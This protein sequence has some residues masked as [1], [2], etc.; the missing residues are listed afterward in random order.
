M[1]L[2]KLWLLLI[3]LKACGVHGCEPPDK[4]WNMCKNDLVTLDENCL[5][6][7]ICYQSKLAKDSGNWKAGNRFR[8]NSPNENI[9]YECAGN[10]G[11][12]GWHAIRFSNDSTGMVTLEASFSS[13]LLIFNASNYPKINITNELTSDGQFVGEDFW[14]AL[15]LGALMIDFDGIAF[16]IAALEIR[17]FIGKKD[18][19]LCKTKC[20]KEPI[21]I[22]WNNEWIGGDTV[23][24]LL[25]RGFPRYLPLTAQNE[26]PF[27]CQYTANQSLEDDSSMFVF[28]LHNCCPID[29]W[30]KKRSHTQN[31][32]MFTVESP[33][34]TLKYFNRNIMTDTFFNTTVTYRT[35]STVFMPYD[36][37]VRIAA[38]TPIEDIWTEEEVRQ[39]VK[40]KTKL[41]FQAVSHCSVNSGRDFLTK[42][43]QGMLNLDLY[44]GCGGRSCA[45]NCYNRQMDNHL[46]YF[47]F[48]NSVC[49][50][51][52]TEKFW[53]SLRKLTVPVVLR[54]A[55]FSGIDIPPNAFI[56]A[57][58]FGTVKEL[59]QYLTSLRND[60][61]RY[62]S[63]FEW[64]KTYRKS[65]YSYRFSPLCTLCQMLHKKRN[66]SKNTIDLN[67]FWSEKES[68]KQMPPL[69]PNGTTV[70]IL[71][72]E[73]KRCSRFLR[74]VCTMN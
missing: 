32:V 17:Q 2:P 19:K 57:D 15:R 72:G 60:T 4:I 40:N 71:N 27:K 66:L 1:I 30:P 36:S 38:D 28:H 11:T 63:H 31:Y 61:E 54:R 26:C 42:A 13:K 12:K 33:V 39:K 70:Q 18:M 52:I 44:G 3:A 46:F 10:D 14:K 69:R 41:A 7:R 67:K 51:Y 29:R 64:T 35:D 49:P 48:E 21:V 58:D 50:Q 6:V 65:P 8:V 56:A 25:D 73:D 5:S 45:T 62:L 68:P 34:N 43:L 53:R 55:V 47:A 24:S 16:Q 59:A 37:L 74:E 9:A 20:T 22:L 23:L